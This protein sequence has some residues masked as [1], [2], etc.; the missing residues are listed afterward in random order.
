MFETN[1]LCDKYGTSQCYNRQNYT[2]Y[3]SLK[4]KNCHFFT[5]GKLPEILHL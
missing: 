5:F 4:V 3:R 1:I 2:R